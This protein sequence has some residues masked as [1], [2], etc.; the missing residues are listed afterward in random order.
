LSSGPP[1]R[2][3][4]EVPSPNYQSLHGREYFSRL[5][6]CPYDCLFSYIVFGSQFLIPCFGDPPWLVH[7][8]CFL[9][10]VT[11]QE[12]LLVGIRIH[13]NL[14]LAQKIQKS[15]DS[16]HRREEDCGPCNL[17]HCLFLKTDTY[18]LA[19]DAYRCRSNGSVY[20]CHRPRSIVITGASPLVLLCSATITC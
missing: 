14:R 15:P 8:R 4:I 13:Q 17:Q 20:L 1:P 9:C 7:R 16:R 12:I 19:I 10:I 6:A 11:R 5:F 2:G 18:L 3:C